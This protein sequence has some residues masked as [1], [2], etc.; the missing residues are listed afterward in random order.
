M[1]SIYQ[2]NAKGPW[3]IAYV[4]LEGKQHCESSRN[5]SAGVKGTHAD[6]TRLLNLREG[7][8]AEGVPITPQ[9]G[10]LTFDD[11]AADLLN[12]CTTNG[13]RSHGVVKRRV[14]KHLAP[15]FNGRR[16]ANITTPDVRAYV[17]HRQK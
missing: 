2:R 10:R 12:D 16:M 1:G 4:G 6:A 15:Y 8:I 14:K 5:R 13:K 11:A 9:I 7:K 3:W 17:A